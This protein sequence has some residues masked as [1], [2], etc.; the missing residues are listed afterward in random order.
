MISIY[1]NKGFTFYPGIHGI[2]NKYNKYIQMKYL[3]ILFMNV[4]L[5]SALSAQIK[6]KIRNTTADPI[7]S[8]KAIYLNTID[9]ATTSIIFKIIKLRTGDRLQIIGVVKNIGGKNFRSNSNQQNIQLWENYSSENKKMVKQIPFTN[10]NSNEETKI[11]YERAAFKPGNEFP[12]DYQIFI[13]YDP[14]I[15]IDNNINNDDANLNNNSLT[16][17]PKSN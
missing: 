7:E 12:P 4:I 3:S 14:D 10:L 15:F 8:N 13:V 2:N 17:N 9:P 11:I 6:S 5:V 1:K 16:K